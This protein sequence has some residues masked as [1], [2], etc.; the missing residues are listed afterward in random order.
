M[1]RRPHPSLLL[2]ATRLASPLSLAIALKHN[3]P[4]SEGLRVRASPYVLSEPNQ[5]ASEFL[6]LVLPM[7]KPGAPD[8]VKC[9]AGHA[10][11][12]RDGRQSEDQAGRVTSGPHDKKSLE[13]IMGRAE[14]Q[15]SLRTGVSL[16]SG[17]VADV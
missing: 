3:A 9:P 11:L 5:S 16:L 12:P 6:G 17:T 13:R 14:Q 8:R 2:R 10:R 1:G 4:R 7:T 15:T